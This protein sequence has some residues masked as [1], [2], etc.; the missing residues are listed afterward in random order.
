[1]K[2]L[3]RSTTDC[4][5]LGVCGGIAEY[6]NVDATV[7][8]MITAALC[9]AGGTGILLYFAAALIMPAAPQD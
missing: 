1:M 4:R 2:K 3:Y 8:R 5:V 7:V 9:I 6:L